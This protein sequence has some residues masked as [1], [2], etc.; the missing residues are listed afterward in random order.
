MNFG[1]PLTTIAL[2]SLKLSSTSVCRIFCSL[3]YIGRVGEPIFLSGPLAIESSEMP[4]FASPPETSKWG[5]ITPIEPVQVVG[6]AKIVFWLAAD[7]HR[8][9]VA[10]ARANAAHADDDR[11]LSFFDQLAQVVIDIIAAGDRA[12]GRIDSQHDADDHRVFAHAVDL[13]HR[14]SCLRPP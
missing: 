5:M 7:G 4:S 6:S 1:R 8:D 13:L 9:V 14:R 11:H 3:R 2:K 10:A 12:A